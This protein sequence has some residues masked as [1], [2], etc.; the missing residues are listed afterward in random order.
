MNWWCKEIVRSSLNAWNDVQ[1]PRRVTGSR[2][3]Y[4]S[5]RWWICTSLTWDEWLLSAAQQLA[6]A[7]ISWRKTDKG[8]SCLFVIWCL[9]QK[10]WH[11]T[12]WRQSD[13]RQCVRYVW[14][15]VDNK[16]YLERQTRGI[17]VPWFDEKHISVNSLLPS[18]VYINMLVCQGLWQHVKK[19]VCNSLC[20]LDWD[21]VGLI[22]WILVLHMVR[23]D[24]EAAGRPQ[25]HHV[26]QVVHPQLV[27]VH[28]QRRLL[29]VGINH[30]HVLLPDGSANL[31][32]A[33]RQKKKVSHWVKNSQDPILLTRHWW[34]TTFI[35]PF[36]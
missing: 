35:S 26:S 31:F 13:V 22:L 24:P 17:I 30:P 29:V 12:C 28:A 32:L 9:S 1:F 19:G 18:R 33:L 21:I 6:G 3:S 7:L 8:V 27:G 2:A 20:L 34:A 14:L 11:W 25:T 10:Y 16:D 5:D 23:C 15:S 4:C 36:T